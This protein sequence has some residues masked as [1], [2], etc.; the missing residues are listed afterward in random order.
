MR[1]RTLPNLAV[2]NQNMPRPHPEG[3][4][5]KNHALPDETLPR[6][7][8]SC[9]DHIPSGSEIKSMPRH[10]EPHRAVP[11]LTPPRPTSTTSQ[12]AVK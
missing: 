11:C 7:A 3:G 5:D 12:M 8:E 1:Y 10:A 2:R 9:Y 4:L 6:L